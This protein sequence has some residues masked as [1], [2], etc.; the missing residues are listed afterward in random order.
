MVVDE[1]IVAAMMPAVV[2]KTLREEIFLFKR[3][4]DT[5][6]YFFCLPDPWPR[7]WARL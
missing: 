4:P 1:V 5:P 7:M 6:A 3:M 2:Y